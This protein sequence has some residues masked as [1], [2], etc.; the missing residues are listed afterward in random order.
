M[1]VVRRASSADGPTVFGLLAQLGE[2]YTPQRDVFDAAFADAVKDEEDHLLFVADDGGAVV[3]YALATIA[4]LFYTNGDAAQLQ[5]LVVDEHSR[6]RG[7]GSQLVSAIE[8]ECQSRG[9]R[10]LTVATLKSASFYER[11]DYRSTADFL[12]KRFDE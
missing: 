10:Q 9:V 6:G 7:I 8:E 11:L 3:G 4:R 5:E 12:K 1:A 2:Q